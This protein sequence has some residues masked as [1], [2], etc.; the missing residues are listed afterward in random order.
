M[1][2]INLIPTSDLDAF[3][4]IVANAYP[5]SG[6]T[7]EEERQTFVQR[8]TE[9]QQNDDT[10]NV[11][12]LYRNDALIGGMRL[13]D[14]NANILGT[15]ML[16]GGLGL[17]CVDLLHKKEKVAKE[18]VEFFVR[19]YRERGVSLTSLYPFRP[20]FYKQMGF[21]YGTKLSRYRLKP[22]HVL[23]GSK[24]HVSLLSKDD[25]QALA[26]C[27]Q[28]FADQHHGMIDRPL[29]LFETM[30]S[31]RDV[32]IVGYRDGAAI[33]GYLSFKFIFGKNFTQHEIEVIECVYE[34]REA[35]Q[36][37]MAFLHSQADQ[38]ARIT[39][40]T[41]DEYFHYLAYD[42]RDDSGNV[43]PH[44]YHQTDTVG[45]G[46][47]YRVIDVPGVFRALAERNFGDRSCVLQ[48]TVADSLLPEN[49]GST[50]VV[51]VDGRPSVR[52]GGEADVEVR[53][54]VAEFS[55][56]LMGVVPFRRLYAYGLA[57]I[58]SAA[59][60]PLVDRLFA[61]DEKPICL[62]RF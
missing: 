54:D 39:L 17:V 29:S 58:S 44:A 4:R 23:R 22:A 14:F 62:T 42:P 20:D 13:L 28:R 2:V 53:L 55:S 1:S 10:I 34:T 51:F 49:S 3:S 19:H 35:L 40:H 32:R 18:M 21:G 48:L 43:M 15:K 56:L 11:Y 12:G 33:R 31:N 61:V 8:L 38:V 60:I 46:L 25:Q 26:D 7:T 27:Y 52:E 59:L 16:I 24:Q 9:A 6:L 41:L 45:V 30:L 57:E 50:I 36:E 47:M 37:L 5:D